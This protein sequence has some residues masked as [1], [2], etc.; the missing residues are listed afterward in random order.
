MLVKT[1]SVVK[2]SIPFIFKVIDVPPLLLKVIT[3]YQFGFR[4]K[5]GTKKQLHSI[6]NIGERSS[7]TRRK[8]STQSGPKTGFSK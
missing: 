7:W 6:E 8:A 4:G 1:S 3:Q 5:N 2:I